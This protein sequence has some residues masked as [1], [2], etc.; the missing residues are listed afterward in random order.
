MAHAKKFID[1]KL[2]LYV[3]SAY[4]QT[5]AECPDA[6]TKNIAIANTYLVNGCAKCTIQIVLVVFLSTIEKKIEFNTFQ[7]MEIA[8]TPSACIF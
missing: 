7:C 1:E 4:L 3:N 6:R 2:D 5:S 8:E